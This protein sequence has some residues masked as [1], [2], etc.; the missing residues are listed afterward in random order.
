[1]AYLNSRPRTPKVCPVCGEDVPPKSLACPECGSDHNT[2]WKEDAHTYDGLD[3]PDDDFSYDEFVEKEFGK[4][5]GTKAVGIKP[6]WWVA[7]FI[8]L[9]A[10]FVLKLF[11]IFQIPEATAP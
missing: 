8:L 7:T 5:R 2:G 1:M 4:N 11:W 10:Y 6:I 3:L 9:A